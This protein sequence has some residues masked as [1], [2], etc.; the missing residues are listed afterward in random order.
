M[1]H[2]LIRYERALWCSFFSVTDKLLNLSIK[3]TGFLFLTCPFLPRRKR[4]LKLLG[5][6]PSVFK[7]I[8][9]LSSNK[10]SVRESDAS[11]AVSLSSCAA[12]KKGPRQGLL[13]LWMPWSLGK[14]PRECQ[15]WSPRI[16]EPCLPLF[17]TLYVWRISG[18]GVWHCNVRL[19]NPKRW[20]QMTIKV[21][22]LSGSTP[23]ATRTTTL[24]P[25]PLCPAGCDAVCGPSCRSLLQPRS[26]ILVLKSCGHTFR[27]ILPC[28]GH[29]LSPKRFRAPSS[30]SL[31]SSTTSETC[32]RW[33]P[34]PR[35]LR[36]KPS[37]L[38]RQ[39]LFSP[40]SW[41]P[42]ADLSVISRELRAVTGRACHARTSS[43][44]GRTLGL[45]RALSS[46]QETMY[47]RGILG[48]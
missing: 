4:Y 16:G 42:L 27:L 34:Q 29:C 45:W 33:P 5:K 11:T 13:A 41:H 39:P 25:W 46:G 22:S 48:I 23:A 15:P 12:H 31:V 47:Q 30:P 14:T 20:R 35:W 38:L 26:T 24:T 36:W 7:E 43:A 17:P 3:P 19:T 40:R 6:D 2:C 37:V 18:R 44:P 8:N 10:I 1:F 9:I 28:S 32:S 21:E